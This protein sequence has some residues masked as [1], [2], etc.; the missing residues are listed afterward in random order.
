MHAALPCES[1]VSFAPSDVGGTFEPA[2][3]PGAGGGR[4]AGRL[5]AAGGHGHTCRYARSTLVFECAGSPLFAWSDRA[6]A[7]AGIRGET[8]QRPWCETRQRP[9]SS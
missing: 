7:A 2:D 6:A 4:R 9:S 5:P 3:V 1:T 8:R